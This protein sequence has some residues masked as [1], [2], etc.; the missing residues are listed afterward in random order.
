M[1]DNFNSYDTYQIFNLIGQHSELK[2]ILNTISKWLELHIPN[3]LVTIMVYS[4]QDQTLK[5][6]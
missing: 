3:A 5:L 6:I 2:I 1:K 4:E